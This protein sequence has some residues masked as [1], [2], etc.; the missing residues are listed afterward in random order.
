MKKILPFILFAGL[1]Y[2]SCKNNSEYSNNN[3]DSKVDSVLSL[4]TLDEKIGQLTLNAGDMDQADPS[5]RKQFETDIKDGRIGA[6][7]NACGVDYIRR[8]QDLAVNNTRL[9]IPLLF[10]YDVIHGYKTIF[11]I[12]LAEACSWDMELI[13][14]TA[15]LSAKEA[16]ASGL[17]WTFSPMVDITRDPRW[18]RVAEGSGED[19]Y[20]ASLIAN[21]KVNGYQGDKLNNPY[22]MAACVKHFAAYGAPQG[23]RDYNTVDMSDRVLRET[24][25][26]PYKAAVDAGVAT[27]MSSFNELDGVPCSGNRYLMTQILRNEWGFKG[28]VVSDFTSISELVAHGYATNEKQAGEIAMNAGLDMDMQDA[29]YSK[30]LK[31]SLEEGKIS[32][33]QINESVRKILKLKYNLGL[34]TNPYLYLDENREKEISFSK[35]LMDHALLSAEESIVLLKN[36]KFKGQKLLPLN[37]SIKRIA[38]IGPLGDNQIDLM[39]C[40]NAQGEETKVVTILNGLKNKFPGATIEYIKGADFEGTD[41]SGF[42]SAKDIALKSDIVICAIGESR[43]QNG[44]AASRSGIGLPGVQ[45]DLLE[46]LAE[47]G[48]PIVAVVLAGRPLTIEWLSKNINAILFAGHLGTR[49]GDAIADILS[50]DYNP[51]G[52]LVM[53]FPRNTGQIPISYNEKNTGRPFKANDSYTSKYLDIANEP[54]YP[55]GFGLSYSTFEYSNLKLNKTSIQDSDSLIVTFTLKNTGNF[56]G[57][58]I[59][60]LY[61]RDLVGSVTRPVKELKGFKKTFLKAGA[62]KELS[63]IVTAN[64]LKFYDANMKFTAEPG[65]FKIFVGSNSM[66]LIEADFELL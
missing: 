18:G 48:K 59:A 54:L 8:L 50:G 7:L 58:E 12:P 65:Q 15:R 63:F 16:C 43:S 37:K 46:Q 4:M 20:L 40:W 5:I 3:I 30:Y 9:R 57:K 44:E 21:A 49:S 32:E 41:K 34:F 13:K 19:C 47:T 1:M 35:E 60:Q 29:V 56:D 14:E 53:T 31:K 27:V 36:A 66:D 61:I 55:F 39:G 28:F 52:K 45:E 25:L 64:D 10:G 38:L 62:Q 11:P 33:N 17:N 23:G 42:Y 6:V 2:S 26:L 51:S 24:Y 22:T